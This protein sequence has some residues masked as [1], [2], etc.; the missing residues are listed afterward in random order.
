[1]LLL[2]WW[3]AFVIVVDLCVCTRVSV[4][5]RMSGCVR[6]C[7]HMWGSEEDLQELVLSSYHEGSRVIGLAPTAST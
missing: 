2:L 1:M 7:I 6:A 3:W 4:C 5:V